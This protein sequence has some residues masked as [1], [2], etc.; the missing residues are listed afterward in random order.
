MTESGIGRPLV[1][2]RMYSGIC[3]TASGV[4]CARRRTAVFISQSYARS[5]RAAAFGAV[6]M[7]FLDKRNYVF[8]RRLRQNAMAEAKD[9][10]HSRVGAIEQVARLPPNHCLRSEQSDCSKAP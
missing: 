4:P 6:C 1:T 2:L 5:P 9:V 10:R 3:D 8:D 7:H